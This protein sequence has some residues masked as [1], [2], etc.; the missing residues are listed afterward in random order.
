MNLPHVLI[1]SQSIVGGVNV[2]EHPQALFDMTT[3]GFLSPDGRCY[4]FDHRANG[5]SRGEGVGTVIL[6]PLEAAIRDGNTIRAVIRNT[7]VNQDGRTP[8]IALPSQ[9]AQ[10][11]LIRSVYDSAGLDLALTGYVEAHGTG[12]AV[13]DPKEAGA[14][15]AAW[16]ERKS[17]VPLYVGAIK[18]NIGHLEGA[19][20]V[21]GIIKAVNV[22]ER[23]VIPPNINFEEVN[24]N[25]PADE[26]GIEVRHKRSCSVYA[27]ADFS[28]SFR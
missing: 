23:A 15:A 19:S 12:T 4:S 10:E 16:R 6:K 28:N 7:G 21:A 26:W 11:R 27:V 3:L 25:I 13:G 14:I 5:Y 8:G 18:S 22:L 2:I 17:A 24:P 9:A 20:G 1:P